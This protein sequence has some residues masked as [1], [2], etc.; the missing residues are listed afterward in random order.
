M[1]LQLPAVG[2][3]VWHRPFDSDRWHRATV[4]AHCDNSDALDLIRDEGVTRYV[5]HGIAA[6]C[7]AT[8]DELMAWIRVCRS[9]VTQAAWSRRLLDADG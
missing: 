1:S 8:A 9:T 5:I 3:E 2:G 6:G 7:W 4:F